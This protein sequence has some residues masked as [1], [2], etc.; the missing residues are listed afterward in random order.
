MSDLF[1]IPSLD[2][3]KSKVDASP[4]L[5][6]LWKRLLCLA[7]RRKYENYC[8]LG[9]V[10]TGEPGLR[11][12]YEASLAETLKFKKTL[13][14]SNG[15]QH[16]TWCQVSPVS[17]KAIYFDWMLEHL[18]LKKRQV[19]PII[20]E[21]IDCAF[22]H[23]YC[24]LKGRYDS[25][26]SNQELSMAACCAIVG[27]LFGRKH[28]SDTRA[29]MLLDFGLDR[30]DAELASLP[31]HG[32]SYEGSTYNSQVSAP[33]LALIADVWHAV[34]GQDRF[35]P[36][37]RAA[38]ETDT[39]LMG[40]NGLLPPWDNYGWMRGYVTMSAAY[41]ARQTGRPDWLY[42]ILYAGTLLEDGNM[43][44]SF[45]DKIWTIVWWPDQF[46]CSFDKL[47]STWMVEP[48]AGALQCWRKGMR[49]FQY[50]DCC[51]YFPEITR[52]HVN[53][54]A[55][56][57]EAYGSVFFM[58][59][60]PNILQ[61]Q[62]Q[63]FKK[64]DL[65]PL[66][67][68]LGAEQQTQLRKYKGSI[69]GALSSVDPQVLALF[70]GVILSSNSIVIDGNV[71]YAPDEHREG[72]GVM[73]RDIPGLQMIASDSAEYYRPVYDIDVMLRTSIQVF[74]R[75]WV[76][77]DD[78]VAQTDHEFTWQV[79]TRPKLERLQPHHIQIDTIE[80][81]RLNIV[82]DAATEF[83][84]EETDFPLFV[85]PSAH[86][87]VQTRSGQWVTFEHLLYPQ[88]LRKDVLP[89]ETVRLSFVDA[90]GRTHKQC[91]EAKLDDALAHQWDCG[92]EYERRLSMPFSFKP[93]MG[94][95]YALSI[96]RLPSGA[97][98]ALNDESL[99]SGFTTRRR[100]LGPTVVDITKSLK[101]GQN[102]LAISLSYVR[103]DDGTGHD[104]F[105][106]VS[107]LR[108]PISIAE[109]TSPPAPE[110]TPHGGGVFTVAVAGE[111]EVLVLFN[112]VEALIKTKEVET[113][114]ACGAFESEVRFAFHDG[115]TFSGPGGVTIAATNPISFSRDGTYLFVK[116]PSDPEERAIP[117]I[118]MDSP[119][120]HLF[121]TRG[122][123]PHV[124][125]R[126]LQSMMLGLETGGSA[127][128]IN[129]KETLPVGSSGPFSL[130]PLPKIEPKPAVTDGTDLHGYKRLV[131]VVMRARA[132]FDKETLV[133]LSGHE[134]WRID[135]LAIDSLGRI[136]ETDV[137]PFLIER[138]RKELTVKDYEFYRQ[139]DEAYIAKLEKKMPD[140]DEVPD[141]ARFYRI[142]YALVEALG[143]LG[144]KRALPVLKDILEKGDQFYIVL[145]KA[146]VAL[147]LLC[148][149]TPK[150]AARAMPL[151][152]N[153]VAYP[154]VNARTAAKY[155]A[156][157]M[158]PLIEEAS[159]E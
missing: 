104:L 144:D 29:R 97:A 122:R 102:E 99:A 90:K 153:Y 31:L 129:E 17:R 92:F 124:T 95:R 24:C 2:G 155:A 49:L 10:V 58:D 37:I 36:H 136:G 84:T 50:W 28:G 70:P 93:E 67:A 119:A 21:F 141:I 61:Q 142:K 139:S 54:N 128:L 7:G 56:V 130:Y 86:R 83:E 77:V 63:Y 150:L 89:F 42:P 46:A 87:V 157:L 11:K 117:E 113:N 76:V 120:G 154:E 64:F 121:M 68:Q 152:Q 138:L 112:A 34:T 41:L 20:D 15:G 12:R 151:I 26:H 146:L 23:A 35:E 65:E 94:K 143:R 101:H 60:M 134:D 25:A 85:E 103:E 74:D 81:N 13:D 4:I 51:G 48:V 158:T 55:I 62:P 98:V 78:V 148:M 126:G 91:E 116:A 147:E 135:L 27:H 19:Q 115:C 140:V 125:W 73:R 149:K 57:A 18:T 145:M 47:W 88:T 40:P 106:A 114:A 45:D 82:S 132:Q 59:G 3:L 107:S 43:C 30:L 96:D 9:F 123:T 111:K 108:G 110:F 127:I 5:S 137:V 72:T 14:V 44:W 118:V 38:L 131:D 6:T 105:D 71:Y 80:H 1:L 66:K 133:A 39:L 33:T 22:K 79:Y 69:G 100:S 159:A 8:A 16:H 52:P 53:P 75:F 109:L 32:Y 156:R